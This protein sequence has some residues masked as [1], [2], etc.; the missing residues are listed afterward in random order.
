MATVV[1][2]KG[3]GAKAKVVKSSKSAVSKC[4][5][6]VDD[7]SDGL[8]ISEFEGDYFKRP[9]VVSPVEV[10]GGTAVAESS[11]METGNESANVQKCKVKL[12]SKKKKVESKVVGAVR[13]PKVGVHMGMREINSELV[14]YLKGKGVAAEVILGAREITARFE[15]LLVDSLLANERLRGRIDALE[16]LSAKG[17]VISAPAVVSPV[18]SDDKC[19]SVRSA[20][21][22]P[23]AR[24][25]PV[26]RNAPVAKPVSAS[27]SVPVPMALPRPVETWSMVVKGGKGVSSQEVERK[28]KA[29]VGPTLGVR[30]HDIF[31]IRDG[32]VVIRTPSMAEREKAVANAKFG[33]LG[34]EVIVRDKLGPRVVVQKVPSEIT[35]DEF[36][37]DLFELNFSAMMCFDDFKKTVRLVSSPWKSDDRSVS[38]VLEGNARAMQ[39]LLDTD[40]CYIKWFSFR[41]RE[42]D[43][44]PCCYRCL[45]FDHRINSCRVKE[46]ICRCCGQAGH[47]AS[48][49]K[50]NVFC[51]NCA[52]R[53]QPADHFMLSRDCPI[54]SMRLSRVNSRH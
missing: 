28:V 52:L 44:V 39:H 4:C 23:A 46:D 35:V 9:R 20:G 5:E 12:L 41:V 11:A 17:R 38:V 6:S 10:V 25:V 53:G 22:V 30:V 47:V 27:S 2:R 45:G 43:D 13:G 42:Y 26:A 21:N 48:R 29:E 34:L 36:M 16:G 32:G 19:L 15:G 14:S 7:V 37:K 50:N 33:E 8:S 40:R 1:K 49:C 24:N 18:L 54:F 51:R 3:E 31:P